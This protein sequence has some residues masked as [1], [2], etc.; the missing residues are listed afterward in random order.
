MSFLFLQVNFHTS[1]GFR[2][3]QTL[4]QDDET[5]A[6]PSSDNVS[7]ETLDHLKQIFEQGCKIVKGVNGQVQEFYITSSG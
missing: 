3:W 2:R 6:Q 5:R 1:I 7:M 4:N